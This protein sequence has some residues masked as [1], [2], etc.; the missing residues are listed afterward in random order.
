MGNFNKL[1]CILIVLVIQ[2]NLNVFLLEI[3]LILDPY[4]KLQTFFLDEVLNIIV[5]YKD[6]KMYN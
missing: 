5:Q 2:F 4:K 3:F 6:D 1:K